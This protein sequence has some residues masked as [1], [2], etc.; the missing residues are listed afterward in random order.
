VT[1]RILEATADEAAVLAEAERELS[2]GHVVAVPTDTV[3]GLA[4]DPF[5]L[6]ATDALFAIKRR[7]PDAGLPLLVTGPRQAR[8]LTETLPAPAERLMEGFWPG[9]LTIVL[10]RRKSLSLDIGGDGTTVALRSPA[11]PLVLELCRR[12]GPL[13]VT[14]ANRHGEPELTTAAEVVEVLGAEL[15]L[16][17]GGGR[18]AGIP[19]TVADCTGAVPHCLRPGG[20][21]WDEV[22]RTARVKREPGRRLS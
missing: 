13:A 22:V 10:V 20:I 12:L 2:A 7:P 21:D 16:V 11:H 1:A 3:Y 6:G 19:S 4:V 8:E 17:L 18:C 5:R 9:A 14:S 15:E